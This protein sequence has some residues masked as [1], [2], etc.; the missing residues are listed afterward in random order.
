MKNSIINQQI[1]PNQPILSIEHIFSDV[2]SENRIPTEIKFQENNLIQ[3]KESTFAKQ[4]S[5]LKINNNNFKMKDYKVDKPL[6]QKTLKLLNSLIN[7][8]KIDDE[9]IKVI[10]DHF[11]SL[12]KIFSFYKLN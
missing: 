5:G 12:Y 8:K 2:S 9:D 10:Y 3:P 6:D 7:T 1:E 11:L 4:K